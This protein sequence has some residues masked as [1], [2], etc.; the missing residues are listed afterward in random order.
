MHIP[1]FLL[2]A[3]C[4]HSALGSVLSREELKLQDPG[5]VKYIYTCDSFHEYSADLAPAFWTGN[6][7]E[8]QLTDTL[9]EIDTFLAKDCKAYNDSRNSPELLAA[10]VPRLQAVSGKVSEARRLGLEATGR[11]A[12]ATA[13]LADL[14]RKLGL[15]TRKTPCMAKLQ[16]RT[17]HS[18]SRMQA[19]LARTQKIE[20]LCPITMET[21]PKAKAPQAYG[22]GA[23]VP[24]KAAVTRTPA[25]NG[26]SDLTGTQKAIDDARKGAAETY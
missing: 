19:L 7:W 13:R 6:K 22:Q 14:H 11:L 8:P 2:A 18:Q 15:D 9:T 23:P 20:K 17:A 4:A 26:A 25:S 1:L 5:W 21:A 3:L 10:F 12:S 24:G 16:E